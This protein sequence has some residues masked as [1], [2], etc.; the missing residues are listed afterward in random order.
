MQSQTFSEAWDAST[1][2]LADRFLIRDWDADLPWHEVV[3]DALSRE[4]HLLPVVLELAQLDD[5]QRAFLQTH[6]VMADTR[7]PGPAMLLSSDLGVT[8]LARELSR[9]VVV[10]LADASR[11][12]LRMADP[13]VFV[14]L[15]W[16]LPL[17]YL[18]SLCHAARRWWIPFSGQWH[19]LGFHE[20]PAPQWEALPED[21]SIALSN[22]GLINQVLRTLPEP[23]GLK[24]FWRT[25]QHC[26]QWL[27]T[28]QA[29]AGLAA[30]DDCVAYARHGVVLGKLF[31]SHPVLASCLQG[32]RETPGLYAQRTASMSDREWDRV[33]ADIEEIKRKQ[34]AA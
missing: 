9:H 3:P 7:D 19:E 13:Q 27:R 15:L 30:A 33:I 10:T 14:Q 17:P 18:A 16:I 8:A 23:D 28:A 6:L 25:S 31:S 22:V 24:A 4:A 32:A 29:E 26:N 21:P 20:R 34:E 12:M 2:L 11:A 5:V 1:H